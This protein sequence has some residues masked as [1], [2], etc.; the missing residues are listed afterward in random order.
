MAHGHSSVMAKPAALGFAT[1]TD[2]FNRA[3]SASVLGNTDTGQA[4][5]TQAG[6]C[7][8][9]SNEFYVST[10]VGSQGIATID[11]GITDVRVKVTAK[12]FSSNRF[13][14]VVGRF[15]DGNNFY[16]A[17]ADTA[18]S[19]LYKKV[20]GSFTQLGSFGAAAVVNDIIEL[21][22]VGTSIALYINGSSV[23]S[24]TDSALTSGTLCGI[25]F[26]TSASTPRADSFVVEAG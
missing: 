19:S 13:I 24:V 23:I 18:A 15:V 6:T 21:R 26:G 2:S 7:G 11:S 1:I 12:A 22:C 14:G 8:I 17:Q 25:R 20:A 5:T 10:P 16:L 9:S 3:D 4:W